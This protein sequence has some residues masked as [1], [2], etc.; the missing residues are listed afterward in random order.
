MAQRSQ[1]RMA[2]N[3]P[4]EE[5]TPTG[6]KSRSAEWPTSLRRTRRSET[7]RL[8]VFEVAEDKDEGEVFEEAVTMQ[9]E[10]AKSPKPPTAQEFKA[11]LREG[12][13]NV[14]KKEQVEQMM[15]QIRSNSSALASLES[16]VDSTSEAN[17]RRFRRI[18]DKLD[19]SADDLA[20][21]SLSN[22][23]ASKRAAFDKAR[24]SMTAWPIEGKDDD[25]MDTNF[26]DFAVEALLVPDTIVRT[27]RI[28]DIIRVRSSP[29]NAAYMEVLVT[30]EDVNERD[31]YFSKAK[32]LAPCRE[33]DGTSTAVLRMNIPPFLKPTF[34]LLNGHGYEIKRTHREDTKKYIKLS[35]IHI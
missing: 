31:Y 35:L 23:D 7:A 20:R 12:L 1:K 13:A 18:E 27:A 30:F 10:Q 3:T 16:K 24:R 33:P 28:T 29:Q 11:M 34:K 8:P 5:N 26:K 25:T 4:L 22:L 14:A 9:N 2:D 32:N 17:E 15:N 21:G 19:R 6:K